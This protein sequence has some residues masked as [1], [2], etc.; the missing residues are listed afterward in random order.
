MNFLTNFS[1]EV[2]N[3]YLCFQV[4]EA[5]YGLKESESI[6][7]MTMSRTDLHNH[8]RPGLSMS[9]ISDTYYQQVGDN[10]KMVYWRADIEELLPP[11]MKPPPKPMPTNLL[12]SAIIS[13]E[14]LIHVDN[15]VLE[16]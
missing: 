3:Y 8:L 14:S 15:K 4:G 13:P 12:K 2:L 7:D 5:G 16:V 11:P 9:S 1:F 6:F 10:G